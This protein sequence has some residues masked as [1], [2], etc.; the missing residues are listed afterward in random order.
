MS[1]YYYLLFIAATHSAFGFGSIVQQFE[2]GESTADWNSTW[3]APDDFAISAPSF[4]A[5]SLGG[6]QD[7][8]GSTSFGQQ[9]YREFLNN[10]AN[11]DLTINYSMSLYVE[12]SFGL[13]TPASGRFHVEASAGLVNFDV[14]NIN[15]SNTVPEPHT[16]AMIAGLGACVF[17]AF[18][19]RKR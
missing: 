15:I 11:L 6:L 14:D 2:P 17:V 8:V 10:T 9:A 19:R 12:I 1:P 16:Y 3:E 18:R 4:L 13:D 7:G 5:S